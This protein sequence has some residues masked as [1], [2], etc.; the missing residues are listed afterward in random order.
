MGVSSVIVAWLVLITVYGSELHGHEDHEQP[1][2]LSLKGPL[3]YLHYLQKA[4]VARCFA[5][6]Y[7]EVVTEETFTWVTQLKAEL[8]KES[9]SLLEEL[10]IAYVI[11]H[12]NL[13]EIARQLPI[14][15]RHGARRR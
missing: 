7:F 8:L 3:A 6:N 12:G 11:A 4:K 10:G 1:R 14:G 13:L 15:E 9:T 2:E 5:H